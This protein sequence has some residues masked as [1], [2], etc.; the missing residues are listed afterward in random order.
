MWGACA[1]RS[2]RGWRV[3]ARCGRFLLYADSVASVPVDVFVVGAE[4]VLHPSCDAAAVGA[5]V[6]TALCGHWKHEGPCRWPHNNAIDP[7]RRP[8]R[9]R[10]IYVADA[11]EALT[12]EARIRAALTSH[13]DW[14]L[15]A[16]ERLDLD[17]RDRE[18]ADRLASGPRACT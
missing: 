17:E 14:E 6:T 10:T 11:N 8:A 3:S 12:V 18:L 5:A 2:W 16:I 9:F 4:L 15:T 1:G 13:E 7:S